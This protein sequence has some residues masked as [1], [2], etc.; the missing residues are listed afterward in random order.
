MK[1]VGITQEGNHL[2]EMS[3]EEYSHFSLLC[4]AIENKNHPFPLDSRHYMLEENFD[5]TKTFDVIRAFSETRFKANDFQDIFT[6]IWK[7]FEKLER[8]S[9]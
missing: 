3:R 2:V 4:M 1:D 7:A 5:F 9:D 6:D 8:E